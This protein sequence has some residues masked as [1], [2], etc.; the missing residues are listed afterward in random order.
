M[1]K[2]FNLNVSDCKMKGNRGITMT[3]KVSEAVSKQ[4]AVNRNIKPTV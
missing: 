3:G 2:A 1:K 4:I